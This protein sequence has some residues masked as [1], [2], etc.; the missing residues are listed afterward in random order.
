MPLASENRVGTLE[1]EAAR[2]TVGIIRDVSERSEA[3][4]VERRRPHDLGERVKELTAL[5]AVAR[6]LNESA[7]TS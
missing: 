1:P 6:L 7:N 2:S 5:H 3:Q 4:R